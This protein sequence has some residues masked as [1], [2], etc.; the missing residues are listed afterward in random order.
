MIC[1]DELSHQNRNPGGAVRGWPGLL[2]GR[3][4][5]PNESLRRR[6]RVYWGEKR[7]GEGK[8]PLLE[9]VLGSVP[10]P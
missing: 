8:G 7:A 10:L 4:D 5:D 6:A 1:T 9:R 3:G 2:G